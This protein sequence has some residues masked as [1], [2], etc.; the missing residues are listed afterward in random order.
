MDWEYWVSGFPATFATSREKVWKQQ[1]CHALPQ[2]QHYESSI[3]LQFVFTKDNYEKYQFDIDNL[4]EPVFAVLTSSLHWFSGARRN[5]SLWTATKYIG[6]EQGLLIR[7]INSSLPL[8]PDKTPL[9]D[10]VYYGALPTRA[11]DNDIPLWIMGLGQF[12]APKKCSVRLVFENTPLSIAT[13]STGKVKPIIDCLYPIIGGAQGTPKDEI[14]E[15]LTVERVSS[16]GKK[17]ALRITIWE[18]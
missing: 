8:T 16:N 1:L 6:N 2:A 17:P 12:K 18:G 10:E 5:I 13:I 11:T 15:T 4:C 9:F 14:I 7:S 3:S